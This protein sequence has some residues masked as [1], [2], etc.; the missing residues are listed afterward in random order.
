MIKVLKA[1][2]SQY[3]SLNGRENGGSKIEFIK[4]T[5]DN[6]IIGKEVLSDPTWQAIKPELIQ[7]EEIEFSPIEIII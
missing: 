7:L 6:W 5:N 4:D 3:N 2:E 1:T